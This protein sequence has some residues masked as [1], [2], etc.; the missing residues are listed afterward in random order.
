M[1]A[2]S[3]RQRWA[4]R[5]KR[6]FLLFGRYREWHLLASFVVFAATLYGLA[7]HVADLVEL[8]LWALVALY[9]ALW[10]AFFVARLT[11]NPLPP[12][13]R[14]RHVLDCFLQ[15]PPGI[16]DPL[17]SDRAAPR[18][19]FRKVRVEYDARGLDVPNES[20]LGEFVTLSQASL[21]AAH[22]DLDLEHRRDVYDR[23]WK[24]NHDSFL[25]LER[26]VAP[27]PW[28]VAALSIVLPLTEPGFD[29]LE[30]GVTPVLGLKRGDIAGL[31][32][33]SK[34]LLV[35]TWIKEDSERWKANVYPCT[36]VLKHL[37]L[38]WDPAHQKEMTIVLEPDVR[39]VRKLATICRF[40]G[41]TRTADGGSL[42]S[43]HFPYDYADDKLQDLYW[44]VD[45]NI[46]ALRA[47]PI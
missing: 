1:H 34:H 24:R 8:T 46:T 38:F 41:P 33:P 45:A 9:A 35:D 22:M 44:Q 21:S 32:E 19:R 2:G 26:Q 30:D 23:W 37:S 20:D 6:F 27:H 13:A 4:L 28:Q 15:L 12:S 10:C 7:R 29:D 31:A 39:S 3:S 25:L 5:L 18:Y 47:L 36:L 11:F 16:F 14:R 42:F 17:S 40:H 43:F